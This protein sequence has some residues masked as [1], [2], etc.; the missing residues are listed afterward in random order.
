MTRSITSETT[1]NTMWTPPLRTYAS[2]H[3][4]TCADLVLEHFRTAYPYICS[5]VTETTIAY[6][7]RKCIVEQMHEQAK[8]I[9]ERECLPLT[10]ERIGN[11]SLRIVY[12]NN[13]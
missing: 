12:N 13:Y 4:V 7:T 3:E 10:I 6:P 8:E 5:Y 1:Q 2:E 9:I 11:S